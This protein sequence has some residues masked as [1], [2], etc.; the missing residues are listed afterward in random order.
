MIPEIRAN[1]PRE[2]SP[3]MWQRL[4]RAVPIPISL[5]NYIM[6]T[7]NVLASISDIKNLE[8]RARDIGFAQ[9]AL[10]QELLL[11]GTVFT[12]TTVQVVK[13]LCQ[14][15]RAA[16]SETFYNSMSP[17]G[18]IHDTVFPN[19]CR[20]REILQENTENDEPLDID[21]EEEVRQEN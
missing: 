10:K 15:G 6:C 12:I 14:R 20:L 7:A 21:L 11:I 1:N 18:L 5:A 2:E 8:K 13:S 19:L 9:S 16:A 17:K 4:T 3:S